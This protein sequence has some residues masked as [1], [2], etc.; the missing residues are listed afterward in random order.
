[1]VGGVPGV[2]GGGPG[3]VVGELASEVNPGINLILVLVLVRIQRH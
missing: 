1:M 2:V 3:P